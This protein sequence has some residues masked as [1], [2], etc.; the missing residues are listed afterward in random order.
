MDFTEILDVVCAINWATLSNIAVVI[1][2]IFVSYQLIEM[3]RTTYAQSYSVAR[4]ILQDDKVRLARKI[5]FQLGQD[6]KNIDEWNESDEKNAEIVCHTYDAVGQM[7]RNKL[8]FKKIIVDSWGPS[9]RSSWPILSPLI[10]KHRVEFK[11]PEIW[12]DYE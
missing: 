5:I 1:T 4:E 6:G 11:A 2:A 10:S 3:R 7:V 12:D 9:L 8:L